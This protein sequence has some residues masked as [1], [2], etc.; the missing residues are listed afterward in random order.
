MTRKTRKIILLVTVFSFVLITPATLLYAW[1]YSFDWENKT[2]VITGGFYFKSN[3]KKADIYINDQLQEEITPT[4]IKRLLPK[5]YKVR[6]NKQGYHSW[7][8]TLKIESKM[9]TE[10]KNIFLVP[11]NPKIEIVNENLQIDFSLKNFIEK[12]SNYIFY[13]RTPSYILYKTDKENSFN[14]QISLTPLPSNHKYKVFSSPNEQIAVLDENNQLYLLNQKTK[15]FE[16][17]SQDV[18]NVQFS[19]DN[20]KL[21]YFTPSEIWIYHLKESDEINDNKE[22]VTRLSQK[23]E[24]A[25]W[26]N[27]N[28]HIIFYIEK[29]IKI[30]EIDNR[31]DRNIVSLIKLNIEEMAYSQKD[32]KLYLTKE[33]KLL[34]IPLD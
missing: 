33:N 6:I 2:A 34:A 9:V 18:Q 31:S 29:N 22:L 32:K 14:E 11:L 15:E 7:Q 28:E 17:I 19:N 10:A 27:T 24:Q 21:L 3:P 8:K 16:L 5:E 26:C 12:E 4:L 20:R 25:I 30:V 23:I 13:A 1:G